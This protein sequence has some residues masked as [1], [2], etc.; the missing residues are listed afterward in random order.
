MDDL[1]VNLDQMV[2]PLALFLHLFSKRNL[3]LQF[4]HFP[5][6][7]VSA[8]KRVHYMPIP[9]HQYHLLRKKG[10]KIEN[11]T[12]MWANAHRDGRPAEY[13]WRPLFNAAKFG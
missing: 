7:S 3:W 5:I 9:W 8:E 1:Q 13:R 4:P 2:A 10:R 11:K 12:R 6:P